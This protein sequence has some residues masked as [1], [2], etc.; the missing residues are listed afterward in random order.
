[1]AGI[2]GKSGRV[3]YGLELK[4]RELVSTL[5]LAVLEDCEKDPKRKLFWAEKFVNRLLPQTVEGKGDKGEIEVKIT[6]I[7]YVIPKTEDLPDN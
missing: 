3:G 4:Q 7:E 6:G 2:K 1:M 5:L